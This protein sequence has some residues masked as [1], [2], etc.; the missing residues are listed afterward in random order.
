MENPLNNHPRAREIVYAIWWTLSGAAGVALM[1]F[2]AQ[3]E[4]VPEWLTWTVGGLAFAGT[5]LGFTA[6]RNVTGNDASGLPVASA[7]GSGLDV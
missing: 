3:P 6:Q 2:T 4:P 5:Y 1:V 7:K